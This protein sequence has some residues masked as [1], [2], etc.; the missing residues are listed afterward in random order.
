LNVGRLADTGRSFPQVGRQ[1]S[2]DCVEK[3]GLRVFALEV[4]KIDLSDRSRI[5]D[6]DHD[7]GKGRSTTKKVHLSVRNEFFNTID[8]QPPLSSSK[9]WL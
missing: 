1:L 5:D 3:L 4:A 2:T 9:W 6:H 7:H 8:L